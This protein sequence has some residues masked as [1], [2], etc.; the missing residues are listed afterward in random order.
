M[1]HPSLKTKSTS[2][3]SFAILFFLVCLILSIL[4]SC[5]ETSPEII[6]VDPHYREYVSGYTSGMVERDDHIRIELVDPIPEDLT[7]KQLQKYFKISPE[8]SGKVERVGDRV[9]QF[10]PKH[11]LPSGQFFTATFD[12][13][14][15]TKVKD[16]Y[17]QFQ[18]QFSTFQQRVTV[19]VDGLEAY[20]RHEIRFQKL[21]GNIETRDYVEE[22]HIR[23][24]LEILYDGN[25]VEYKL[26][27]GYGGDYSFIVDSIERNNDAHL[28]TVRWNGKAIR[29][30]DKGQ[31]LIK[32]PALSDFSVIAVNVHDDEDQYIEVRFGD[33]IKLGQML[34]GLVRIEDPSGK[35][36]KGLTYDID[37]NIVRVYLPQ[38]LTGN[39]YVNCDAGI[40]NVADAKMK[41][42][43]KHN[44]LL[45]AAKPK[46]RLIG[47]GSIL[48]NSQGLIFPFEAIALKVVDVRIIKIYEKNIQH[49]LQVNDLDGDDEM[50][51]FGKIVAENKV[52]LDYDKSM[53]LDQWNRHVI[54]LEKWIKAEPGAIYQ[55]ALRFNKSYTTCDCNEEK[56][57]AFQNTASEGWNESDWHT[58]GFDG[59]STWGRYGDRSACDDAY[60]YGAA[61]QR[62]ILASNIGMMFKLEVDKKSTAFLTDMLTAAPMGN[63]EVA[64]YDYVGKLITKG[65]TNSE[66]MFT[67]KLKRK[68]FLMIAKSGRQ[69]GYL[70][71]TDG[72]ANS[73]SKF[74]VSGENA[75]EGIK[76]YLYTERGVWRP[77][78][79]IYVNFMLQDKKNK[80]PDNHPVNFELKDP[81]GNTLY[82]ISRNT[83]VNG[84]YT[85]RVGT[86]A[87][88]KTGN[89]EAEVTVG[90][91][92]YSKLLKVET[93]KPNRLKIYLDAEAA[94]KKDSSEIR[95][96]WLHGAKADGLKANVEL[97]LRPMRTSFKNFKGYHFDSPIR[98]GG[99]QEFTV[100][101]GELNED[102]AAKFSNAVSDISEAPGMLLANYVTKVYEKGGDYSIDRKSS[103]YSPYEMYVG[104][105]TPKGSIYD[106]TLETAKNH[107]FNFV[108]VDSEGKIGGKRKIH[109][110]IY[111][112]DKN[113]W[114]SGNRNVT[115]YNY[116]ES[117]R[118]FRDT[119]LYTY[120]GHKNFTLSIPKYEYGNYLIVATDEASGHET[121]QVVRFD[122]SY[123][124]R[125]N[126][127]DASKA[128]MLTFSTDKK[129]YTK[130]ETVRL[131]I[132]SPSNGRALVSVETSDRI[133]KKFWIETQQG[134]TVHEFVTTADMAPNA[135]LHVTMI[136]P[137]NS[138][139]NDLPI[140][141][142]GVMPIMVDDPYTH[143]KPIITMKDEIRPESTASIKVREENGRK[144]SYTLAIVDDGLLD[145]THFQTPQPW[146]T[147]YAKEALGIQ[148]WDMYDDV[149]GAYS[150]SLDHLLSVGGGAGA[151]V[152]NGPK[153]NR[154]PPMVR[155]L[156][157]FEVAA[158]GS[159]THKVDIPSYVGSVRVMVVARDEESYG[160]AQ[161][162]VKVKKP[163][164]ILATMPR[165]LGP[166][167]TFSLPVDVFAMEKHIKN[168]KVSIESNDMFLHEDSKSKAIEFSK[169]GDEIVNFKLKTKEKIGIGK[170]KIRAVCGNEVSTQ[171]IEIDIRPSNP[172]TFETQEFQL[173][174]GKN[175]NSE[176]IFDGL[177]GSQEATVSVSTI[178]Q[179]NL[180]KRMKYLV[181]YPHGCVEQ[182]TSSVFPQ[183]YLTALQEMSKEE[184]DVITYNV[185]AGI[186]RLQLFQ[187]YEG[188]F[189]YWPGGSSTNEWGTNYGGHFL[190]EAEYLG[191]K[192]PPGLKDRW[193]QYQKDRASEWNGF[194]A[195]KGTRLTQAYRLY[196]LALAGS[197]DVGAMNR[198]KESGNLETT[199]SWRLA[200]AYAHIGQMETA[201]E[202]VKNLQAYVPVFTELSETFGSEVRDRAIILEA[203]TLL[204]DQK[205][206]TESMK[207][208][209]N[210]LQSKS[211]LSTQETAYSLI[212]IGRFS[213]AGS[214]SASSTLS[215]TVDGKV[216]TT[217]VG[218][219]LINLKISEKRG[220]RSL[221]IKNTGNASVFVTVTTSKI[222][223]VGK[224]KDKQSRMKAAIYY[225]DLNGKRLNP[226]KIKQG[227]EFYSVV[228]LHNTTNMNYEEMALNQIFP[229]GWEVYNS[230]M[231]GGRSSGT[232]INYQDIRD[233]RVLTYYSLK[234]YARTTVKI[235]LHA[236]YKGKFY[237]P[238]IYTEAMYD[239]T[240]HAQ[241][242]GQWVEIL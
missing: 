234:A 211:W 166:G 23:K 31:R 168:V 114:Y 231:Y 223:K 48:P 81:S 209:A 76:G 50:T 83:H 26:E 97:Q 106:R 183:L 239:H 146:N 129:T 190:I 195:G 20:N 109:L 130:G 134:E 112:M 219:K 149:L 173:A 206:A 18:F 14:K 25:P 54:D 203:Q 46:V 186:E 154:F 86:N 184:R 95:A 64:Y 65:R 111:K 232:N 151:I 104:M 215:L 157:P 180:K 55:V 82:D 41:K 32:V 165:V 121:G 193:I 127:S 66:G 21:T 49:F 125:S 118:L 1:N 192:L 35:Q 224:E 16:G 185:K 147:F 236:T 159:K 71:L 148:T 177:E 199:A 169:V 37:F 137:H 36:V 217:R 161:K 59:Y 105:K 152:G 198:L 179:M 110:R 28:M 210:K 34:N 142:Y 141:M 73:M 139:K 79:S 196:L 175:V 88:G 201:R 200:T 158:G 108:S 160:N 136:Q 205:G 144:M 53:D 117:A 15:F 228:E 99:Y 29:S 187:N 67:Q 51:R 87:N 220:K 92:R 225:E 90:N 204:K 164:M 89:Y 237:L 75:Q 22:G 96:E 80:L 70:K 132:P 113:W 238:G 178:P 188:G 189:A 42:A 102:G 135:F 176:V 235:R 4:A 140:R 27:H 56:E 227:T 221:S 13:E 74:D 10:V 30:D 182:T 214:S 197:P 98:N 33:P 40:K 103:T 131:S 155:F 78:D 119:M 62:N 61:V 38:R 17:E 24:T 69:R 233:D 128:T 124:S 45:E 181:H 240:I 39:Y 57:K 162:T 3:I 84:I 8:I 242:K 222:P 172:Y 207:Y 167:E 94:N 191:Y 156:G 133:V 72:R 19:E 47:S 145:L 138:T 153:A 202:M 6:K 58:W 174:P 2:G 43:V 143:L 241:Q 194:D 115:A 5:S 171:E 107:T 122:W 126:R 60:Y 11:K 230:R 63:T 229:S 213:K 12:L 208:L 120:K 100:F 101:E 170:V 163:L 150:G 226:S 123:W 7:N 77:G 91:Y 9:I 218:K 116:E 44:I 68:P 93:I 216:R 212:A 85:F 52:R